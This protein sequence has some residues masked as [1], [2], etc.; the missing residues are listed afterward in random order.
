MKELVY[1]NRL[2][3]KRPS[4]GF[5]RGDR[6]RVPAG[7][8]VRSTHPTRKSWTTKR[9]QTVRVD[10]EMSGRYIPVREA[11]DLHR[12]ELTKQGFDLS[13]MEAWE[14]DNAPE[15]YRMMVQIE[16][17]SVRWAGTGGYWCEVYASAVE[18]ESQHEASCEPV[19]VEIDRPRC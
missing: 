18:I 11:L 12:A 6:V 16:E 19:A 3:D 14:R 9:A 4:K 13:K 1:F 10:H 8:T 15:Y 17:S 5:Q 2:I 7:V